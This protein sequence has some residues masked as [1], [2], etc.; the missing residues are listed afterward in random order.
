MTTK[1][2]IHIAAAVLLICGLAY[3]YFPL[4][5][6]AAPVEDI[7]ISYR[8]N[9]A[10]DSGKIV[11]RS[12]EFHFTSQDGELEQIKQILQKYTYHRVLTLP[13]TRASVYWEGLG[14]TIDLWLSDAEGQF[15]DI[16]SF[17]KS[18]YIL[19]LLGSGKYRVGYWGNSK[20][21]ALADELK[22]VLGITPEWF[23]EQGG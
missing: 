7:V 13:F 3:F 10:D 8:E 23:A 17:T 2:K 6:N 9:G 1:R 15:M 14:H 20:V 4:S 18:P 19:N 22:A 12:E 16:T 5:Y 11:I 21:L